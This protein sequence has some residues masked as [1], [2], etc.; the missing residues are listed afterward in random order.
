M[1]ILAR[2]G[3]FLE[4]Y[5][6]NFETKSKS[7]SFSVERRRLIFSERFFREFIASIKYPPHALIGGTERQGLTE[8]QCDQIWRNL[9]F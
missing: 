9:S 8:R 4:I 2:L 6:P 7:T 1:S 3:M 5:S